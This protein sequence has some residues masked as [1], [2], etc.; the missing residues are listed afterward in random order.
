MYLSWHQT[1]A[2]IC[3]GPTPERGSTAEA[4][5]LGNLAFG[6]TSSCV[7]ADVTVNMTDCQERQP[8]TSLCS[9]ADGIG[10]EGVG[11]IQHRAA[12]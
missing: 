2:R 4:F 6:R 9:W 11:A 10:A 8:L 1:L 12:T 7:Q 5:S 3:I